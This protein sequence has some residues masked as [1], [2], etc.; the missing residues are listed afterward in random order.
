[1]SKV[2][3][4]EEY[5]S[6]AWRR[7]VD[8]Y[9]AAVPRFGYWLAARYPRRMGFSFMEIAGGS[10]RDSQQL[11]ET[12]YRAVGTDFD[13][14][15]L[16]YLRMRFPG[17]ESRIRREDAFA[18]D[19]PDRGVDVTFSNGFWV[20]FDDDE[21]VLALLREQVRVTRRHAVFS[22]Q[23]AD[24]PKLIRAFAEKAKSDDLYD[25]RFFGRDEVVDLVRRS[26]VPYKSLSLHKFGGAIDMLYE[27]SIKGAWNPFHRLAP[28]VVP[29]L[30][31]F[32]PWSRMQ[33][34]VC[35]L[36]FEHDA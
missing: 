28:L 33:R 30:Y 13:E 26:G 3:E 10:C 19:L 23:N 34:V 24:N 8:T 18:F 14:K 17:S 9:L 31:R 5:W 21:K 22:T 11:A 2:M 35:I 6:Q 20:L 29:Y 32:L 12:G 4:D 36:D 16:E 7:H 15:T 25:I 27:R 1:M